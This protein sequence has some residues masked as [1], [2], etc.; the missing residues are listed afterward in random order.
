M[1][2]V[3]VAIGGRQYAINCRDGEE[4]HLSHLAGI[5][6]A[7]THVAR[8]AT[9]GLTEVRQLLFAALF[10]AD[11]INDL[12]REAAGRQVRLPLAENDDAAAQAIET[13]AARLESVAER[14]APE[15]VAP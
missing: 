5:V 12:K 7:K 14:L 11:E 4:S 2:E 15:S 6:D 3:T 9:P 13:L 10:L 1:A 8:Q